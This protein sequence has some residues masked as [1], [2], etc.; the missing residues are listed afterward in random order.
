MSLLLIG[1]EA[2]LNKASL[3]SSVRDGCG[4]TGAVAQEATKRESNKTQK[5]LISCFL[6]R[7]F[8]GPRCINDGKFILFPKGGEDAIG[9]GLFRAPAYFGQPIC[10]YPVTEQVFELVGSRRII[11]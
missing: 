2:A 3:K 9:P 4:V 10:E 11:S 8:A 1:S 6:A 7:G 5:T